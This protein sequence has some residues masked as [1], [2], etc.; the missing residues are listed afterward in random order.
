MRHGTTVMERPETL[1]PGI[2]RQLEEITDVGAEEL[3]NEGANR[4]ML[5][6]EHTI[7]AADI[8]PDQGHTAAG[9]FLALFRR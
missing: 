1:A 5:T 7:P 6:D 8:C 9:A 4:Q 2:A 3:R